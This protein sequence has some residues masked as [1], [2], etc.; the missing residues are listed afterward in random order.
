MLF[1][2]KTL[3]TET[4][5]LGCLLIMC[6]PVSYLLSAGFILTNSNYVYTCIGSIMCLA[7]VVYLTENTGR[8]IWAKAVAVLGGALGVLYASNQEQ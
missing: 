8:T 1:R 5:Y 3:K 4:F 7:A 6:F 2:S